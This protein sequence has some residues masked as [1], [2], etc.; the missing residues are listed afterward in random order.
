MG[1]EGGGV[2]TP[3]RRHRLLRL[4]V[5]VVDRATAS[6]FIE[7]VD[8]KH[9]ENDRSKLLLGDLPTTQCLCGH[10]AEDHQGPEGSGDR[11]ECSIWDCE[12]EFY[13]SKDE[14][15]EEPSI[16]S[17]CPGRLND[18][19]VVLDDREDLLR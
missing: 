14:G 8:R 10:T 1:R 17:D 12:C 11:P 6:V 19:V 4:I 3:S 7:G 18:K 2:G 13:L 9:M 5:R 16:L 15:R